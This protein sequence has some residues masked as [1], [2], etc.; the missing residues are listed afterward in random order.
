MVTARGSVAPF[1]FAKHPSKTSLK[2]ILASA[3][4][5]VVISGMAEAVVLSEFPFVAQMPKRQKTR[6]QRVW[7]ILG[8]YRSTIEREGNLVPASLASALLDV[9]HQRVMQLCNLGKLRRVEVAGHVYVTEQSV[10]DLA[11]MERKAGRP[12][13]IK[14]MT[15]QIAMESSRAQMSERKLKK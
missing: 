2:K 10:L 14:D 7:D 6:L 15:W 1:Q 3:Q 4:S 5:K 8:E 12:M 9:S 13:K 11:K